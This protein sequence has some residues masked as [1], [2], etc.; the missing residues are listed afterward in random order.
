MRFRMVGFS[1]KKEEIG[2]KLTADRLL[3]S[4]G[5]RAVRTLAVFLI[6]AGLL[7]VE[8]MRSASAASVSTTTV[9]GTVYLA[10]GEPGSGMLHVSWPAFTTADG[11]AVVA[12]STDVTI[13]QDGFVSVNLAPNLG[14]MPG[15]LYYTAVYYMSDGS[16]S[17]QYWVV[18][19]AAQA[20]LAQVQAQVMPAAQAVQAVNKAYVDQAISQLSQTMLTGAGGSL[21][22]PLYLSGDPTQPLQAADKHYVD[23]AVSGAGGAIV[24]AATPDQIAYYAADGTSISGMSTVPVTSGG[25]GAATAN[26]ALQNLGGISATASLP[27]TLA[28]PLNLSGSYDS[29][30]TNPNQAATAQNVQNVAPRSVKEFGAKGNGLVSD[31]AA[32]AGSTTIQLMDVCCGYNFTPSVVGD[33]ISLPMV[34]ADHKTLYTTITS[35]ID[36]THVTVATAPTYS[37]DGSGTYQNQAMW[38]ADDYAAI[39]SAIAAVT[40]GRAPGAGATREGGGEVIFPCGYYGVSSPIQISASVSIEGITSGCAEILY[41]GTSVVDAVVEVVPGG[42]QGWLQGNYYLTATNHPEIGTCSGSSCSPALPN[43]YIP[44]KAK[45]LSIYGNKFSKYAW[46]VLFPT[47]YLAENISMYGGSAGCFYTVNGVQN[48]WTH[49]TCTSDLFFGHG[50]PVNGLYF[51]GSGA[52]EGMIPSLIESPNITSGTG[53]ALTFNCVGGAT[54]VEGVQTSVNHQT[55]NVMSNSG[56]IA[57]IGDLFEAGATADVIAGG[58]NTFINTMFS[59]TGG[60]TVSGPNNLFKNSVISGGQTLAISGA[61]NVFEASIFPSN[62][63][64]VDSAKTTKY[65]DLWDYNTNSPKYNFPGSQENTTNYSGITE[66][67]VEVKGLWNI[68]AQDTPY[69]IAT[70]TLNAGQAW[71]AIFIGNWYYY[72][73]VTTMPTY[74]EL[75][76]TSNTVTLSGKTLT[77]SI[78]SGGL[79]QVQSSNGNGALGFNGIVTL[80]PRYA[81]AGS[82]GTNSMQLAGNA[83][84]A[85]VQVGGGTAMSGNHGVGTSVQH[86]DGTGTSGNLAKFGANGDVVDGPAN[87]SGALVGTTD[88]QTLTNKSIA[89][90]E[91]NSEAVGTT[92][93][94]TGIDSHAATG[95]AQ[96]TSGTWSVSAALANGTTA[97]TQSGGDNSTKVATTAYVASPGAITPTTV[98]AGGIITGGND[99]TRTTAGTINTTGFTSTG[100]VLPT[101]PANTTKNGRCIVLWQ[102]SSTSY[103]A[104]FGIG[105]NNAPTGLW[106]GSSVTYA[107][108]GTSNW[109]AFSQTS[110]T[111]SA[112]ST[113]AT[114]GAADTT[115]RAEIDFTLQT[116][117]TNPVAVSLYGQV[118]DS[119]ATLTIQPGSVCYWLP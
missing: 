41:M 51:D 54:V 118:S 84:A 115:Y 69:V 4:A 87:P 112:I 107:A 24:N 63:T 15:G 59:G 32:T 30:T 60:V 100:L 16:V 43:V 65:R 13:A 76:D 22:G 101:V 48:T 86:S 114:A 71:K 119:S 98:T 58:G 74:L 99:T 73:E 37:F 56:G 27:Q 83:Q 6:V 85:S 78:S 17:M 66:P 97:T 50:V 70:T 9:Q 55:L 42:A 46:S 91:I 29:N 104:T 20:T 75:T 7:V 36:S 64:V 45:N 77:F 49:L 109:L 40:N 72:G 53:T 62:L 61:D 21:T 25:T 93:G 117:A 35:Y 89:G 10:N 39:S 31:F 88:A 23:S 57:F 113:A 94:G 2:M 47:N 103:S 90:S 105:M 34:D 95:I 11:Q 52:G 44:G 116:G 1:R 67:V 108:A 8:S 5:R 81:A 68:L 38:M 28:G 96:V 18:P 19:A 14:A 110:T 80:V 106:G 92:Y 102:M 82:G 3:W 79:F 33:L 12:D 111:A 26:E